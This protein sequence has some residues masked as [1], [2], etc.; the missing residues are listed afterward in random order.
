MSDAYTTLLAAIKHA[1]S[2][3]PDKELTIKVVSEAPP[4]P[5]PDERQ[6]REM[7]QH[8]VGRNRAKL[9]QDYLLW[10]EA[11]PLM[12]QLI[13]LARRD[14]VDPSNFSP[15]RSRLLRPLVRAP[16]HWRLCEFCKS[17]GDG[18]IG[19]CQKCMGN[20]YAI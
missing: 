16:R 2:S 10:Q 5:S 12:E 17:T 15:A 20:G 19:Y 3:N 4:M 11:W 7:R 13:Q 6:Y 18:D 14:P 1:E 9:E 8:L